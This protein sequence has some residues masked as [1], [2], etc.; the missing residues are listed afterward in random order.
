MALQRVEITV[1][2]YGIMPQRDDE[3][4][5]RDEQDDNVRHSVL[6]D[7]PPGW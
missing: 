1:Q 4:Q 6:S 3:G 7:P 5:C 2:R